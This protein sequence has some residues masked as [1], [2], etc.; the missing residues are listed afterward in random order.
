MNID[1]LE[2]GFVK[3]KDKIKIAYSKL[4]GASHW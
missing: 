3:D 4:T 2:S 1:L